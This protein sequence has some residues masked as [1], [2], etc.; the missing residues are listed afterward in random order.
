M[1]TFE[2]SVSDL[3]LALVFAEIAVV[4]GSGEIRIRNQANACNTYLQLRDEP[5]LYSA[6][7]WH[8][9]EIE[10]RLRKLRSCLE[11][12]GEKFEPGSASSISRAGFINGRE[13][14]RATDSGTCL[15]DL[16]RTRRSGGR[17]G[18]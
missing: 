14:K 3:D 10:A 4:S 18:F 1:D 8:R 12:L 9:V 11:V 2:S 13:H 16:S 15:R 7:D 6:G 5:S 17:R